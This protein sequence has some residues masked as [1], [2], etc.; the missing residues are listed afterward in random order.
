MNKQLAIQLLNASTQ[1]N[2]S[3]NA[4]HQTWSILLCGINLTCVEKAEIQR[5]AEDAPELLRLTVWEDSDST[6]VFLSS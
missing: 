2:K 4:I 5:R 6:S 3:I 1:L